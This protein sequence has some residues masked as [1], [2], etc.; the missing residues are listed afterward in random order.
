MNGY[1]YYEYI[2]V[3][4]DDIPA[5]SELPE[6]IIETIRKAYRLKEETT[7]PKTYLGSTIKTYSI[8]RETRTVWRMNSQ[9]YIKEAICC[10][11]LELNKAGLKLIG[12]PNT[13]M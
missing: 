7:P 4:V 3:Y 1:E 10:L 5:L 6:R 9:Q 8:P 2:L 11:K 12:K 13:P